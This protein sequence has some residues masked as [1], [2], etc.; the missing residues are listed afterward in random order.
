MA[1]YQ[2]TVCGYTYD[3]EKEGKSFDSLDASWTCP[4]CGAGKDQFRKL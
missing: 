4:T 1:K 3:E 2:C